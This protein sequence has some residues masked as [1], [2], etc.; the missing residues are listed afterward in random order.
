MEG[1]SLTADELD[2]QYKEIAKK[3]ALGL[4]SD[5]DYWRELSILDRKIDA[6]ARLRTGEGF[7]KPLTGSL[8]KVLLALLPIAVI[9][10]IAYRLL[11]YYPAPEGVDIAVKGTWLLPASRGEKDAVYRAIVLVKTHSPEDYAL[12]ANYVERIDVA[13]SFGLFGNAGSYAPA[14]GKTIRLT[15]G[16]ECPAHCAGAWTG[17]DLF[18]A[19]IL[20]HEACHSMQYQTGS[21]FSESQCYEIQFDFARK[22]GPKLWSDFNDESFIYE[23]PSAG[24][25]F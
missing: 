17:R 20:I 9:M 3:R 8:T 1:Q 4:I 2:E 12:L 22:T 6:V 24:F 16:F 19:S 5:D 7:L 23:H 10:L 15:R 14:W 13:V 21:G 18:L 25:N 11:F